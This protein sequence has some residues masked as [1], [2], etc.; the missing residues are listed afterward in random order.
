MD[1]LSTGV[2]ST[3]NEIPI[4]QES[5]LGCFMKRRGLALPEGPGSASQFLCTVA[6]GLICNPWARENG[7]SQHGGVASSFLTP[8][9]FS[10]AIFPPCP[11]YYQCCVALNACRSLESTQ[12]TLPQPGCSPTCTGIQH[13]HTHTVKTFLLTAG[14]QAGHSALTKTG[15]QEGET[16]AAL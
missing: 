13:A 2:N 11:V 9:L 7:N 5:L 14:F 10:T 6:K 3:E 12:R 8:Y 16:S 1:Y 4:R 15:I